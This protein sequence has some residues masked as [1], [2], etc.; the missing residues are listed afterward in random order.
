VFWWAAGGLV[1]MP[2]LLGRGPQLHAAW[3][4]ANLMSLFGHLVYG[5]AL[6]VTVF[7]LIHDE[8]H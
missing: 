7:V 6:A 5:I 4:P 2:V 8:R 3:L 1:L